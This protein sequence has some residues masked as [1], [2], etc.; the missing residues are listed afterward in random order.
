MY[1]EKPLKS[2]WKYLNTLT[3]IYIMHLTLVS[4]DSI[5]NKYFEIVGYL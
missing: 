4:K 1:L 5:W 2:I 3:Q